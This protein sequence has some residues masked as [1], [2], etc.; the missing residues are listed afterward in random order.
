MASSVAL[1]IQVYRDVA[2]EWRWRGRAKNGRSV[3]EGGEGYK[4]R[5]DLEAVIK[6][7]QW[8]FE[9]RNFRIQRQRAAAVKA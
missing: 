7:I 4:N 8:A 2:G 5:T 3:I 9:T 6:A 1:T